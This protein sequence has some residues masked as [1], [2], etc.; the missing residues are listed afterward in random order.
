[1]KKIILFRGDTAIVDDDMYEHINSFPW[2]SCINSCGK[3]NDTFYA[4]RTF[5]INGEEQHWFMHH[6]VLP[7]KEEFFIDHINNDGLD[8]RLENLRYCTNSQNVAN[9]RKIK[10]CSSKYKGVTWDK[11]AAKWRAR[12]RI[13][14]K[15]VQIGM[16]SDELDAARAAKKLHIETYGQFS[17]YHKQDL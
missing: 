2:H 14:G 6:L 1:M 15:L 7:K 4:V 5:V 12:L 13:N 3:G 9:G 8:N 16:F 11:V 10:N 17:S